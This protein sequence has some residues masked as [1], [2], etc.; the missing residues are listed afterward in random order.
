M[1][2]FLDLFIAD[3]WE[4]LKMIDRNCCSCMAIDLVATR[5]ESVLARGCV[6][7]Y[8]RYFYCSKRLRTTRSEIGLLSLKFYIFSNEFSAEL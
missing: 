5:V 2:P 7:V 8:V 4:N 3:F 1:K 6:Y